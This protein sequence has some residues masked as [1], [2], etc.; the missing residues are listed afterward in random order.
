VAK[1]F[2]ELQLRLGARAKGRDAGL[3]PHPYWLGGAFTPTV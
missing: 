1:F 3:A 2:T